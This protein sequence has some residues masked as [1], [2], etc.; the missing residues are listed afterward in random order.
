M[1]SSSLRVACSSID[2]DYV[3][4]SSPAALAIANGAQIALMERVCMAE[5]TAI[6]VP[7]LAR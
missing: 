2:G 5:H 1:S 3:Q 7:K 4:N 6:E